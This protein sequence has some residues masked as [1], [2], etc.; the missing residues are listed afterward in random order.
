MDYMVTKTITEPTNA[1]GVPVTL[2]AVDPNGNVINLGTVTSDQS[3]VFK[4]LWTPE[5]TGEYTIKATFAGTQSYGPSS[6]GTAFGVQ[7]AQA[8]TTP[9]PPAAQVDNTYII[10]GMGIAIII[11]IAI[12][13]LL[14]LRKK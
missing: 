6:A 4:K 3:G 7:A 8:T 9:Q 13:G 10:V 2:Q 14:V 12:V 11:A 5:I 1:T